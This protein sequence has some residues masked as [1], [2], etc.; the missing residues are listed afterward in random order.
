MLC[1]GC[2]QDLS[3]ADTVV[4]VE[5]Y[6]ARVRTEVDGV[7]VEAD[8]HSIDSSATC[9]RCSRSIEYHDV[10]FSDNEGSYDGRA[11]LDREERI[12]EAIEKMREV[13]KH[14]PP[15]TDGTAIIRRF[16]D[17]PPRWLDEERES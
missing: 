4:Y 16:R 12:R 15:G 11:D 7:A 6:D 1:G 14:M 2:G 8:S 3:R 10:E 5:R 17:A 13:G 9:N